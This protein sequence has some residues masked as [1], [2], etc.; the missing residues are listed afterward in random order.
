MGGCPFGLSEEYKKKI[1]NE[2]YQELT[3]AAEMYALMYAEQM[4]KAGLRMD[5]DST[6]IGSSSQLRRF[7]RCSLVKDVPVS[8]SNSSQAPQ[9]EGSSTLLK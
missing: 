1:G 2:P 6:Y 9:T 7:K 4:A 5:Q 8:Y 3:M